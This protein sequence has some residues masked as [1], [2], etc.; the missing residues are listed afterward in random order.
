MV[1]ERGGRAS[2]PIFYPIKTFKQ[3]FEIDISFI[4]EKK[5]YIDNNS[6]NNR[7]VKFFLDQ[8]G[9]L[10]NPT[11]LIYY[12]NYKRGSSLNL[13]ER[14]REKRKFEKNLKKRKLWTSFPLINAKH[15]S[16]HKILF[17]S[18]LSVLPR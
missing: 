17:F 9:G 12:I 13:K 10:V 15:F 16:H 11:L 14:E 7:L 2:R 5:K 6:C 18:S 4:D 1:T 8:T 3:I